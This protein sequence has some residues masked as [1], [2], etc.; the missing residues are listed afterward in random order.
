MNEASK[1]LG[2]SVKQEK[3]SGE[4]EFEI[5]AKIDNLYPADDHRSTIARTLIKDGFFTHAS[6]IGEKLTYSLKD[7]NPVAIFR[8]RTVVDESRIKL[9]IDASKKELCKVVEELSHLR[10]GLEILEK[11]G[12]ISLS[13]TVKK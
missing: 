11:A 1:I 9:L 2:Y 5:T 4:G 10:L 3:I 7:D 8:V 13:Q 6:Y 12:E